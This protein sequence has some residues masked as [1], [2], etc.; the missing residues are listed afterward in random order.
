MPR[1]L[2]TIYFPTDAEASLPEVQQV[3]SSKP[4][5]VATSKTSKP[6]DSKTIDPELSEKRRAA[7]RKGAAA[8]KQI[9]DEATSKPTVSLAFA[10]EEGAT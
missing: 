3:A 1:S 4:Q 5:Q 6:S 9:S 7:G 8:K 10:N 2:A